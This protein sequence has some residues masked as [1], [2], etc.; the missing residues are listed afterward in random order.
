MRH[1]LLCLGGYKSSCRNHKEPS[2]EK[3]A[4]RSRSTSSVSGDHE[5]AALL[6]M[7]RRCRRH[8][9]LTHPTH[10]LHQLTTSEENF[11]Y[12]IT[13]PLVVKSDHHVLEVVGSCAM[14]MYSK[15]NTS[16]NHTPNLYPVN[17]Y[18]FPPTFKP[19]STLS[20]SP[21]LLRPP[22]HHHLLP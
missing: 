4:S 3:R 13:K 5:S 9:T 11:A 2:P 19:H 7:S 22:P 14:S 1:F 17:P 16:Y 12:A 6:P 18:S 15:S 10:R 21:H 20:P 8:P